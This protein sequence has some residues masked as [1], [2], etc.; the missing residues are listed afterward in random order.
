MYAILSHGGRQY[1]V[2]AGDRLVVD[3]LDAQ[4]GTVVALEPVLLTGGDGTTALG[5]D[6]DGLR[7]AVTVV[8]HRRGEKLRIFK[9]KAKKRSRKMAGYRSDLTELRVE[10]ILAKGAALPTAT[11]VTE[12]RP[13]SRAAEQAATVEPPR[14][15][16]AKAKA[17]AKAKAAPAKS[18]RTAKASATAAKPTRGTAAARATSTASEPATDSPSAAKPKTPAA[19]SA[20]AAPKK[21][22]T[23]DS[24]A[25]KSD[26]AKSEEQDGA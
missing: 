4:V 11:A 14:R 1:R 26:E 15:A 17:K 3:R 21:K 22:T 23:K 20:K 13:R 25:A 5:K 24:A 10:S 7:V 8:A 19:P 16:A 2:S 6:L 12:T 9:Y 18:A